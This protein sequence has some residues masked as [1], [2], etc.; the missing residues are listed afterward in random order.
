MD[1]TITRETNRKLGAK[2]FAKFFVRIFRAQQ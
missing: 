2:E 1:G